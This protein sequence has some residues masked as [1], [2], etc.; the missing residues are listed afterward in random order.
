MEPTRPPGRYPFNG[1]KIT[2]TKNRKKMLPPTKL[3]ENNAICP[4]KQKKRTKE[5]RSLLKCKVLLCTV[6][7]SQIWKKNIFYKMVKVI[8]VPYSSGRFLSAQHPRT[9]LNQ[10]CVEP[11]RA[12]TKCETSLVGQGRTANA[13]PV[14][15]NSYN[16]EFSSAFI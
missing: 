14:L 7:N 4:L 3:H 9:S 12:S 6:Q 15:G 16:K 2:K 10:K 8:C 11:G 13:L 1:M 5:F